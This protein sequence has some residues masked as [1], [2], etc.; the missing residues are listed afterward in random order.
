[1][2]DNQVFEERK[3]S[4]N[5]ATLLYSDRSRVRDRPFFRDGI[6]RDRQSRDFRDGTGLKFPGFWES[7]FLMYSV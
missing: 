5:S 7:G 2:Q 1:M 6:F 3:I 4:C